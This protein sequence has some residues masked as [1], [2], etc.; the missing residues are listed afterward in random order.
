MKWVE[1][2]FDGL[3]GPTHNYSGLS[4]GNVASVAYQASESNPKVAA[5]QGLEKM[6]ALMDAGF[7]QGVLPPQERPDTRVLRQLG[8]GGTGDSDGD[9]LMRAGRESPE[10]LAAA[11]SASAMW[12]A[13]AATVCPS[14]DAG[15]GRLHLSAANLTSKLHRSIE[16][17]QTFRTLQAIFSDPEIFQVHPPLAGGDA[18]ADEGAANHTR[19]CGGYGEP[20]VHLFVYG[21]RALAGGDTE[22]RPRRFPARQT[23]EACEALA[24]RHLLPSGQV[25]F[26]QQNP[27]AIDA[28]V[29]HN[30]VA[31][32]GNADVIFFHE[33]AFSGGARALEALDASIQAVC[34]CFLRQVCVPAEAVAIEDAV[35]S[36]LFNSQLLSLPDRPG[37]MLL[38][39]PEESEHHPKVKAYLDTAVASPENPITEVRYMNLRESMRNGGGP[40]CLRLRVVMNTRELERMNRGVL[41]TPAL[42]E[43]LVDW[44]ELHYRDALRPADLMDPQL[45]EES[46][47]ALDVLTRL[48]GLGSVFPFQL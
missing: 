14:R 2:N 26:L 34:G 16:A 21:R 4:Y 40:A 22:P 6:K 23:R 19:F 47:R 44:V 32:V 33:Q 24:R 46:R 31:A 11:S 18:L 36:Y 12:T 41:L 1:A 28:G 20:G 37:A 9:V 3:V 29:F 30:D 38:L 39:A 5:L 15:D 13:N 43:K 42:Y 48:L 27:D 35:Q 45:I 25:V 7:V 8:F 10:L 17:E